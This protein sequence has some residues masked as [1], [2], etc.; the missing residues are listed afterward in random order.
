MRDLM[1]RYSIVQAFGLL[2]EGTSPLRK[3]DVTQRQ[4]PKEKWELYRISIA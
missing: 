3:V 1:I 4:Q 2:G